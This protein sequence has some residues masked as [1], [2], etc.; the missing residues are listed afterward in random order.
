MLSE[1]MR[2]EQLLN[3]KEAVAQQQGSGEDRVGDVLRLRSAI[4][5]EQSLSESD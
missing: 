4:L 1:V 5:S 2:K 3:A